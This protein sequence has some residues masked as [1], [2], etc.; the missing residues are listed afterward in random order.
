M[1][2]AL[3]TFRK[4]FAGWIIA[5]NL[6]SGIETNPDAL[7]AMLNEGIGEELQRQ[8]GGAFLNKWLETES[9]ANRGYFVRETDRPGLGGGQT[10]LSHWGE[11]HVAP[12]WELYIQLADYARLRTVAEGR[13]LA[14]RLED[15]L[16]DITV[17]AG[18]QFVLY[19]ENKVTKAQA[20]RLLQKMQ[21]Y[22]EAG[23]NLN[24]PDKGNDP[25]RKAKYLVRDDRRPQ[26]FAVSAVGFQQLFRIE[27]GEPENRFQLIERPDPFTAPLYEASVIGEPPLRTF[28]D[29]FAVELQRYLGDQV[30]ISPGSGKTEFN[31]YLL[32]HHRDS[33]V[34]G[35]YKNG[36]VWSDAK[37]LGQALSERLANR[38]GSIGITMD[39]LKE[40]AFWKMGQS[41]F[42]FETSDAVAVATA[43]A[44]AVFPKA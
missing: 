8:I 21:A 10:T 33:I 12:C 27:Y 25:L 32:C 39:A 42:N 24:D 4:A 17:H 26:Y 41:R 15:R 2:N 44:E 20:L 28:V 14:V 5:H 36:E 40:W 34:I 37:N 38:L 31:V 7:L 9:G 13:G 30:W 6:K 11:G 43:I 23:F 29:D 1:N 16:M 22:G 18:E 35:A 19:V 3:D